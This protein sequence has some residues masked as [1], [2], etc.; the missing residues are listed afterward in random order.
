[1][2]AMRGSSTW[3]CRSWWQP[4]QALLA[5][6]LKACWWH[7]P[8][9]RLNAACGALN[10][11]GDQAMSLTAAATPSR[12]GAAMPKRSQAGSASAGSSTPKNNT[13]AI[14]RGEKPRSASRVRRREMR[15]SASARALNT[16]STSIWKSRPAGAAPICRR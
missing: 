11:P 7:R 1:M 14:R 3:R 2:A 5:T 15:S 8:Q 6:V 10:G 9:S 16:S 12:G 13:Q 4:R